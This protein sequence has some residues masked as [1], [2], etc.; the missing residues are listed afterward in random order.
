MRKYE[1]RHIE[2]HSLLGFCTFVFLIFYG[3]HSNEAEI[4]SGLS[5][6]SMK[7]Y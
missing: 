6:I 3:K 2:S 5:Y 7:I 4:N 1:E